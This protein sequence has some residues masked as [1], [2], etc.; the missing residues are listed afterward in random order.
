M[1]DNNNDLI[2]NLQEAGRYIEDHVSA[3]VAPVSQVPMVLGNRTDV[4]SNVDSKN[5]GFHKI[6]KV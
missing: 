2:V 5:A 3:E 6:R 1:A 4:L